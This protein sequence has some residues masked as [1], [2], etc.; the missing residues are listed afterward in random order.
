MNKESI[1]YGVIGLLIG[2]VITGFAAGQAVNRNNTGMMSMMGMRTGNNHGMM[3][4]DD[5]TMGG[6][7]RELDNKTGDD[8]DKAFLEQM[9]IHHQGA[10]DMAELI[11][12]NAKHDEIKSLGKAIIEAQTKEIQDMKLWQSSWGYETTDTNYMHNMGR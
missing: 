7:M 9:I 8:F 10:I 11:P 5:M 1:L 4:A 3:D 2:V 6:M 12:A